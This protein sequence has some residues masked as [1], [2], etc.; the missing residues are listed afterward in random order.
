MNLHHQLSKTILLAE[1]CHRNDIGNPSCE[2]QAPKP[3]AS[4]DIGTRPCSCDVVCISHTGDDMIC[5]NARIRAS[6]TC[7]SRRQVV[8]R[9]AAQNRTTPVTFNQK[10]SQTHFQKI[11]RL[12]HLLRGL[13]LQS[14][15]Y[16]VWGDRPNKKWMGLHPNPPYPNFEGRGPVQQ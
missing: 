9:S 11:L 14:W 2:K 7:Q 5:T 13:R 3:T 4:E 15:E 12:G 10:L 6:M 1:G 16:E 8:F